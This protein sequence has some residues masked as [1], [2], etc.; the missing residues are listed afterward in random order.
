[1]A[2]AS[3]ASVTSAAA[4]GD[5]HLRLQL[6]AV[7]VAFARCFFGFMGLRADAIELQ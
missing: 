5:S 7:L 4:A 1:L 3:R 6:R 2:P